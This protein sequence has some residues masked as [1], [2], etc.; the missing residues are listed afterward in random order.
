VKRRLISLAAALLA[1][2]AAL[3][4]ARAAPPPPPPK[5]IVV[6]SIDQFGSDLFNQNRARF[7]HG[8]KQL[9]SGVVYPN[10]YQAHGQ[11][12]TC[13]GHASLL[14]GRHPD[15]AGIVANQWYDAQA[16]KAVYCTEDGRNVA[17]TTARRG[18]V[19]PGL[20]RATTFGDWL[21]AA[22]PSSRV[23]T[24]AGKDRSAIMLGGQNPDGAFWLSGRTFDTWGPDAET[25]RRRLSL[26]A[27]FNARLASETAA[28]RPWTYLDRACRALEREIPLADGKVFRSSLPPEP[29]PALGP[30]PLKPD[31]MAAPP[32]IDA[33]TLDAAGALIEGLR[34]G[35]G[36]GT[37][38]IGIGL[39]G[40][41]MVG[42]A[43]GTQGPEMCDQLAR[44]DASLGAFV[45]RL[46]AAHVPLLVVVTADHGG[47]DFPERLTA[48][49]YPAH[50]LD[51]AALLARLNAGV[52]A[53][54]GLDW[55]PLKTAGLDV[56]QLHIVDRA[57]RALVD[58]AL[59]ARI[60]ASVVAA[61]RREPE[62][63][64]AW[65]ADELA[66]T[67]ADRSIPPSEM[68]LRQRMALSFFRG[69]SGD[70][71]VALGPFVT[72]APA[73]PGLILQ[74]HGSPYD[75]NRRIPLLIWWPGATAQERTPAVDV[76]DLAPTLAAIAGVP[77]PGDLEGRPLGIRPGT[78]D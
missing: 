47:S 29:P 40:T 4:P 18:A 31:T 22:S 68:G 34:L 32:F 48:R 24:V 26:L 63:A 70:I 19:G 49:G 35:R 6:I 12:E 67:Q 57:G 42:H 44:L 43:F 52:R 3:E 37:D 73:M 77:A 75:V 8:L 23:V 2:G 11:T 1:S 14:T 7:R 56:T 25:A 13:A 21:K 76:I 62:V 65:T 20:L 15:T 28:P 46:E 51:P 74:T 60:E 53:D 38:L 33:T 36:A 9:S 55:N 69:R 64:G 27:G 5:L 72:A 58:A 71:T 30:S 59:R 66:G 39:S 10:A 78:R 45:Q 61:L 50:R 17:A 41:D 54:T 16:G